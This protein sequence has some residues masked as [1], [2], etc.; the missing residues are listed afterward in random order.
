MLRA[1]VL[2]DL[3]RP[4]DTRGLLRQV[5]AADPTLARPLEI[6]AILYEREQR[7]AESKKAI[8]A[9][10]QL[11]SKNASL[12]Y[13]LAQLQWSRAMA[14]PVLLSVQKLL[15]TA[16][17]LLAA[18]P[19]TLCLPRGDPGRPGPLSTGARKRATGATAAPA[20]V[21]AQMALARAQ[22]NAKQTDAGPGHR[23]EG[24]GPR[25]A[26]HPEAAG[27]GVPD[28]R[29]EEQA[30]AGHGGEA[31]PDPV[32]ASA[33]G[34]FRRRARLAGGSGSRQRRAGAD[35]FRR[36]LRHHRLLRQPQRRR[37]RAGGSRPRG[38][39]RRQAGD[40]LRLAGFA[41]RRRFRRHARSQEGR[42]PTTR[43]LATSA[44]S[45]AARASR[46]WK[47]REWACP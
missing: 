42:E 37:L 22:W 47:R 41:L 3:N 35:R 25:E 36:R 7:S 8:E 29:D 45:R 28:L 18:D 24:P 44:T 30:R 4:V 26:S 20:D 2:F 38:G 34:R 27:P 12:Y 21:Y 17:D 13:R 46:C 16:R 39:L 14:K 31:L 32:R 6:E 33:P 11:G 15:E 10:I 9:A 19:A 43:P 23:E 1:E 5:K 40:V